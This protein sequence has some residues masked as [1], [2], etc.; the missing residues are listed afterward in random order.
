M[1]LAKRLRPITRQE[2]MESYDELVEY[3]P[4]RDMISLSRVGLDA[5][6]FF[7]LGHRLKTKTKRHL[8]FFDAMRTPEI[9]RHLREL[10]VRYKKKPLK[11][12]ESEDHLLRAQYQVF[13]L[14]YGTINQF[15]PTVAKWVYQHFRPQVGILDF[16]AGWG[17]RMI[18]A[19]SMGIPYIGIDANHTLE[20]PYE[21][22]IDLYHKP[23]LGPKPIIRFQPS[24]TVDFSRYE[25]DLIFTSPPYFMI[26]EYAQM[27]QY[28]SKDAFLQLFFIPVVMNAW[29]ALQ[30]GGN[31]ALNMP[32][33][34]YEAVK[35]HLPKL[36]QCIE[37]PLSNRH[38]TNAVKKKQF[39]THDKE[40]HEC[41]FV[42]HKRR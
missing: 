31:M 9:E 7:F 33:E 16:S 23:S 3:K 37:M 25:Y 39:G 15:R 32:E 5:L 13:Q 10:V 21:R 20:R 35:N 27:P 38:P 34:M 26:E 14:Y 4:D 11:E 28:G 36:K 30:P 12:Y 8:S 22:M 41:I 24:E 17:G 42:W 29:S 6:D 18:A 1:D 40:R 2:A 19:M